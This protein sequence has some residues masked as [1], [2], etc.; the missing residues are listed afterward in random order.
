MNGN[1]L[2]N[3]VVHCYIDGTRS[4]GRQLNTWID[5]IQEDL[6]ENNLD[7]RTAVNLASGREKWKDLAQ[8]HQQ[9]K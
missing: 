9:L 2:P 7:W 4:G 1:R 5:N 8:P 6:L 3:R